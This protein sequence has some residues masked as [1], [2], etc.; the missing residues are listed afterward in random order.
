M[1]PLLFTLYV[2]DL[3]QVIEHSQVM[4]YADD[5]TLYSSS[6]FPGNIQVC[7]NRDIAAFE[8]WFIQNKLK[9]NAS[10]TEYMLVANSRIRQR[11]AQ[12]K[13]QVDKQ[14]ITEKEHIK[15]L[16][17]TLTNSLSWEKH[18]NN[19]SWEKHA[20]T[21]I[22]SLDTATEASADRAAC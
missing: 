1:G 20:S 13:I 12:I 16:G 17:V 8:Q 10:K 6:R 14:L 22:G 15:I 5:T 9:V 3:P 18:T 19:L 2:N 21:L 4:L 7:L 11:F